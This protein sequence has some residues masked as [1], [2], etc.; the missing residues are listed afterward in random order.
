MDEPFDLILWVMKSAVRP[1]E[2]QQQTMRLI[3]KMCHDNAHELVQ[4]VFVVFTWC[5]KIPMTALDRSNFLNEVIYPHNV[6]LNYL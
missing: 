1:D 5:D 3:L 6:Q 2:R 4:R